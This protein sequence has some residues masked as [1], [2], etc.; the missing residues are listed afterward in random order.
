MNELPRAADLGEDYERHQRRSAA[1]VG[2]EAIER[3]LHN[4]TP[5]DAVEISIWVRGRE[6]RSTVDSATVQRLFA[7]LTGLE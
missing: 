6:I 7:V 3:E 1:Q 5:T 2:V 4:E